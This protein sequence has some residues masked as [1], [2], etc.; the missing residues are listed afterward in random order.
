MRQSWFLSDINFRFVPKTLDNYTSRT[1]LVNYHH[2]PP[3]NPC[4]IL[5]SLSPPPFSSKNRQ[6]SV[7]LS[8]WVFVCV[9]VCVCFVNT[10]QTSTKIRF[11]GGN[12]FLKRPKPLF[13]EL[14][15]LHNSQWPLPSLIVIVPKWIITFSIA[16]QLLCQRVVSIFIQNS[17]IIIR[18]VLFISGDF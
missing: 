12:L 15:P 10:I 7:H 3:P 11:I 14:N 5:T 18:N 8:D 13:T 1:K 6:L 9:C 2:P 16:L 4:R 17:I